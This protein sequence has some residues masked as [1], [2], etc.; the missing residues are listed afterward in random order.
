M[1]TS[2]MGT[3]LPYHLFYRDKVFKLFFNF[4]KKNLK[5]LNPPPH[6]IMGFLGI[7]GIFCD[8]FGFLKV[9]FGIF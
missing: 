8:Y 4:L 7:L 6:A 1:A 2:S 9:F 3:N 5:N